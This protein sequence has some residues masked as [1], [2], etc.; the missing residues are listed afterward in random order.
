M[1][2]KMLKFKFQDYLKISVLTHLKLRIRMI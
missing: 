1:T 2:I